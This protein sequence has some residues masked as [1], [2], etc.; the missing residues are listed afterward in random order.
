[1]IAGASDMYLEDLKKHKQQV[2]DADIRIAELESVLSGLKKSQAEEKAD[3]TNAL[4]TLTDRAENAEMESGSLRTKV[5]ELEK[6]LSEQKSEVQ[7]IEDYKKSEEYDFALASA[8][9]P[10]IQRTWIISEKLIKT[11]PFA[12]W[13]SFTQAFVAAKKA[14]EDGKGEPEPYHGP[15]PSFLPPPPVDQD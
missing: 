3:W 8:G 1:M 9:I 14:I 4:K 10:E 2:E 5:A 7:V 6:R 13:A 11:D 12:D 15:S